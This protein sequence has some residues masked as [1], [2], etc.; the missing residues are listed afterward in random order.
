MTVRVDVALHCL[1]GILPGCK[2]SH[3]GLQL[4]WLCC[5]KSSRLW[6]GEKCSEQAWLFVQHTSPG[7]LMG[8]PQPICQA[9]CRHIGVLH[10]I[11]APCRLGSGPF[12]L[13][14]NCQKGA[15]RWESTVVEHSVRCSRPLVL[16]PCTGG[17]D[18]HQ[19]G[20]AL[21]G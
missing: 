20:R 6:R 7:I 8:L 16:S 10:I 4:R 9:Q 1:G 18:N 2:E 12:P 14:G 13:R 5:G 15:N 3:P 11:D 21:L 19:S 17:N